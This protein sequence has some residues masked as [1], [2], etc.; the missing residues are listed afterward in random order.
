VTGATGPLGNVAEGVLGGD[1]S[2][3]G[4]AGWSLANMLEE[5][6]RER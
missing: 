5:Q 3:L 6:R 1:L 2:A 4:E